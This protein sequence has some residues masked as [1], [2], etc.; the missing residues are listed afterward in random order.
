MHKSLILISTL[1]VFMACVF[2]QISAQSIREQENFD[3]ILALYNREGAYLQEAKAE[4]DSFRSQYPNSVYSVYLDYLRGNIALKQGEYQLCLELYPTLLEQALHPDILAD[5]HL[6]YSIALYYSGVLG[7]SLRQLECLEK[8]TD[9]VFYQ[10][11]T[12]LWRGR[13]LALQGHYRSA[14]QELASSL[15][16]DPVEGRYDYFITLLNQDKEEEAA[17]LLTALPEQARDRE[18]YHLAWMQYLLNKGDYIEFNEFWNSHY[19]LANTPN[20]DAVLLKVRESLEQGNFPLADS[21]LGSIVSASDYC[22]FYRATV[23]RWRGET[24]AADSLFKNLLHSPEPDLGHYA[25]LERL[26]ILYERDPQS[27]I[28]QLQSYISSGSVQDG[29]QHH[30]L[31]FFHYQ[32]KNYLEAV[33][34]FLQA[35]DFDLPADIAAANTYLLSE[36]YFY[37]DEFSLSQETANRYLNRF[38]SGKARDKAYYRLGLIHF[39][40]NE[41]KLADQYFSSLLQEHP[42][43]PLRDEARFYMAE[44]RFFASQYDQAARYYEMIALS[45]K[46]YPVVLQ[47]LAQTYYFQD[48]YAEAEHLLQAIPDSLTTFDST[49]LQAGIRFSGKKYPEALEIY[50]KAETMATSNFQKTEA[51]SYQ[52]YTLFYLKRFQEA[53]DIFYQLSRDSLNADIYLYQA[54]KSAAQGK[55][56]KRALDLYESFLD[57]F[58]ASGLFLQ[59]MADIA[60]TQYNLGN[61]ES[62]LTDYLNIL[63]RFSR[64]SSFNEEEL[65]LLREV[66]TG[67]E[68]AARR[69]GDPDDVDQISAMLDVVHSDYLKFELEYLLVKLYANSQLWDDLLQEAVR[70]RDSLGLQDPRRQ[71]LELMMAQSLIE[72]D[73]YAQADSLLGMIQA[74]STNRESL[75][76]WADLASLT[77]NGELAMQR[78]LQAWELQSEAALWLKML[79]LSEKMDYLRFEELW[80]LGSTYLESH[81]QARLHRINHLLFQK[82]HPAAQAEANLILDTQ[83]DPWL[84]A[85]A[86]FI[87]GRIAYENGDFASALSSFRKVRLIHADYPELVQN[88]NFYY[89]LCLIKTGARQEAVLSLAELRETLKQEQLQSIDIMLAEEQ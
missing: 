18:A 64:A 58:P 79:D 36:A 54:A 26:K 60:N 53:S 6:N 22:S 69:S 57:A 61:Y 28:M 34:S 88:S 87:L 9:Q 4:I 82:N 51:I 15:D 75:L 14:E 21:L 33:R 39:V 44:I 23:L 84:R 63:R 45:D 41:Y 10:Q 7:T 72:L 71:D 68:L 29:M 27:A 38:V 56:W 32:S 47:R 70:L 11:Q 3:Y 13:I 19:A 74:S 76:K 42:D 66:F 85:Q 31:G 83:I 17:A 86:E 77:G 5:I 78:Y 80:D 16:L 62:A 37:L 35:D 59:V 25:Y 24:L 81:P 52:A 48:R 43:S 30:I 8:S 73:R 50:R 1:I 20:P 55:E 89:I 2:S 67:L 40:R 65:A 46:N 12:H 49:V